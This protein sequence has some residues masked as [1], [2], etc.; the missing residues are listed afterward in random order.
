MNKIKFLT[1]ILISLLS[2]IIVQFFIVFYFSNTSFEQESIFLYVP[3]KSSY[4]DVLLQLKPHLKS[5]N[6]FRIAAKVKKYSLGVKSGKFKIDKKSNNNEIINILRGKGL[7]VKITF[8]NQD[9]L[10]KLAGRI[11]KQIDPDSLSLITAFRDSLFLRKENFNLY[12][13]ISMYLPNTYDFYWNTSAVNFRN[14]MLKEYRRFWSIERVNQA[15]DK[16]INPLQVSVL[17][18]IIKKET[19]KADERNRIAGVYLNRIKKGMLLQADPTII[20]SIKLINDNFDTIIKRVLF[21]DL[22]INSIYNTYKYKG[23]PPGPIS[24][25]DLS[26]INS[27]LNSENHKYLFFVADPTNPGYHKFSKSL[28][29]HNYYRR[30]YVNWLNKKKLYR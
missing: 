13:A 4:N 16:G 5:I 10:E 22:K 26:S 24:M 28:K 30:K 7:T 17:A 2:I 29:K 21:S 11:S 19:S 3:N 18:S 12:N 1:I 8:N 6:N 20:Y 9:R 14:R 27:V 15:K 23:L 25:P